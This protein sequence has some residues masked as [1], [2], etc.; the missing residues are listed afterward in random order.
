[1]LHIYTVCVYCQVARSRIRATILMCLWGDARGTVWGQDEGVSTKMTMFWSWSLTFLGAWFIMMV[2][3][4][5]IVGHA[6][7]FPCG[8]T[9]L[10][11]IRYQLFEW[12]DLIMVNNL[13]W[14]L[15]FFFLNDGMLGN[16]C[17]TRWAKY[18]F[19]C[20]RMV[21]LAKFIWK[22]VWFFKILRREDIHNFPSCL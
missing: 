10:C 7:C 20:S 4:L 3:I 1:M 12:N 17:C 18:L 6:Y 9:L 15:I 13:H 19:I 8:H 5:L 2:F 21:P 11:I 22:Y 16:F 14:Y